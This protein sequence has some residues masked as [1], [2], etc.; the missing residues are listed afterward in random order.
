MRITESFSKRFY[1]YE[2]FDTEDNLRTYIS[3]YPIEKKGHGLLL[4]SDFYFSKEFN[5]KFNL[6]KKCKKDMI[7]LIKYMQDYIL[8]DKKGVYYPHVNNRLIKMFSKYVK[9][10]KIEINKNFVEDINKLKKQKLLKKEEEKLNIS[11]EEIEKNVFGGMI[12]E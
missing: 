5:L 8:V 6:Q 1:V 7:R 2:Y 4:K 11:L 10:D 9:S 12:D 3:D